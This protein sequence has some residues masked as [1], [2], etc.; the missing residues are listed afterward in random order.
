[1]CCLTL[2][3]GWWLR[4]Q[5]YRAARNAIVELYQE[6]VS[7]RLRFLQCRSRLRGD[8]N[9]G[10][11]VFRFLEHWGIINAQADANAAAK[12]PAFLVPPEGEARM[13]QLLSSSAVLPALRGSTYYLRVAKCG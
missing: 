8:V 5:A 9:A 6:D 3:V 10:L 4:V 12:V 7:R 1:M 13:I 2:R 11:R